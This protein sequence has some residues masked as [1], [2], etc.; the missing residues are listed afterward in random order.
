MIR[1]PMPLAPGTLLGPYE[2]MAL[3][4][5]RL[6]VSGYF[7]VGKDGKFLIPT[8]VEQRATVPMTVVLNWTASLKKN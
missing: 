3:I 1:R 6:E 2:V 5:V 8:L 7:N 4:G